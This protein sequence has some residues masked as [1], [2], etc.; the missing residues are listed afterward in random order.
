MSSEEGRTAAANDVRTVGNPSISGTAIE[1]YTTI[2]K[3]YEKNEL[4]QKP[5]KH[6]LCDEIP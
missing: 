6:E 3:D 5:C 2:A 4:F 1:R